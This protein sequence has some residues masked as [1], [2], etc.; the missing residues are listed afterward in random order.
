MAD[1]TIKQGDLL[2]PIRAQL[3]DR[4]GNIQDLT[5]VSVRFHM[6][7]ADGTVVIDEAAVAETPYVDGWAHYDWQT[8]DTDNVGSYHAEFEAMIGARPLTFPNDHDLKVR[9]VAQVA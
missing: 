3:K 2:K 1:F 6:R 7:D 5:G 4:L 8:G 9:I